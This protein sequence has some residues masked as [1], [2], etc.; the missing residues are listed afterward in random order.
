MKAK[1][2]KDYIRSSEL[3][4]LVHKLT[5]AESQ[6]RN[7]MYKRAITKTLGSIE[8]L[9]AIM[10]RSEAHFCKGDPLEM[11]QAKIEIMLPVF[12]D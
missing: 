2:K 11:G 4:S 7:P 3:T 1:T 6:V 10:E 8:S 5:Y 9:V 12:E